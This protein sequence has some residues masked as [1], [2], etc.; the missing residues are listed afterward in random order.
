MSSTY[1][2]RT[3][4]VGEGY[5][6]YGDI[7]RFFTCKDRE[8]IMAG[9][10]ETGKTYGALMKLHIIACKYP[11]AQLAIVRK[12]RR[13]MD[14]SVLETFRRRVLGDGAPVDVLGGSKPD[15]YTYPNGAQ[16]IIR[17]MDNP[18][19]ILSSELDIVYVNQAEEL[20]IDDW[21]TLVTR[22]T[23]RAGN[24]PYS[25][26]IGDCNPSHPRHWILQR[27]AAGRLTLLNTTHHDNPTLW[28]HE[29]G[30]WTAQGQRTLSDLSGLTGARKARLHEGRWAQEE[31]AVYDEF[32]RATHVLERPMD[33]AVRFVVG[34][35]EGYTNPTVALPM[36]VDGDGRIHLV[37]EFYES[38]VLQDD[39][40]A[41]C[42]AMADRYNRPDFYVDP[43]AAGL[44]AAM[45]AAGL[46]VHEA[47]N[48]VYDG[49][50]AVKA[51]LK[52]QGDGRPRL[53]MS[54]FCTNTIS[55]FETYAWKGNDK[56][57]PK[58][59][60]DHAA[61]AIRY[62]ILSTGGGPSVD[63]APGLYGPPAPIPAISK[64][65]RLASEHVDT[66]QHKRWAQ[67]FFCSQCNAEWLKA[68]GREAEIAMPAPLR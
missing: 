55:E 10:A 46:M 5:T 13:S 45:R 4:K 66:P 3:G 40:V 7:R 14:S 21:E 64:R 61:D 8:V 37:D 11:K 51:M 59:E 56:D 65:E 35:D 31:G 25:Q 9:P 39:F 32:T 36:A 49:I 27:E 29:A 52:V 50:Q 58:K 63:Y 19:K 57:Q 28:D 16:I 22:T 43:S 6:P 62:V 67:R 68:Q 44:I 48:R 15:M 20:T 2:L 24:M 33:E 26:C 30:E 34:V 17:G 60:N 41:E 23:G 42:V 38:G 53:T 18:G 47:D 54:S 12:T 1:E